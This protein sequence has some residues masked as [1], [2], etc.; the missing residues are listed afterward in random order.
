MNLP[1]H[2]TLLTGFEPFA[3]FQVNSSWQAVQLI[4]KE[5]N[6]QIICECL[7]VDYHAARERLLCL[8]ELHQPITC[9][10]TGLAAGEKFRLERL[11]RKPEQFEGL[12]GPLLL[13]GQWE[14]DKVMQSFQV[15]NLPAYFSEDA[16]QYVCESTYWT[17]LNFSCRYEF[18]IN[19]AFLH[20]PPLSED[21]PTEKIATGMATM[22]EI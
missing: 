21:W 9:L 7:P 15:K 10:C 5:N 18:P 14:W 13:T 6:P 20:V 11:A 1:I 17:L 16:G 19:S 12:E 3:N 2:K 22:L 8:L 4:A